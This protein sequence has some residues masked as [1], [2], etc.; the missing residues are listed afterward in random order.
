[1][2][3]PR[4][5][6]ILCVD[7]PIVLEEIVADL[8]YNHVVIPRAEHSLEQVIKDHMIL[9]RHK[10]GGQVSDIGNQR[11]MLIG[12]PQELPKSRTAIPL[13]YLF[14]ILE[15]GIKDKYRTTPHMC[16]EEVLVISLGLGE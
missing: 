9:R 3:F 2:R 12:E 7:A 4:I 8:I 1:M 13:R 5:K 11:R 6:F 10:T 16:S 15:L 14:P